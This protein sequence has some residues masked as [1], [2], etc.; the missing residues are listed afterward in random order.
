ME[1]GEIKSDSTEDDHRLPVPHYMRTRRVA[2]R[3]LAASIT[4]AW[5][6]C[7][8]YGSM[9]LARIESKAENSLEQPLALGETFWALRN[10]DGDPRCAGFLQATLD[11]KKLPD[12]K[13]IDQSQ[14]ELKGTMRVGL[15]DKVVKA[16]AVANNIFDEQFELSSMHTV[17]YFEQGSVTFS[18]PTPRE[19]LSMEMQAGDFK[20]K[21]RFGQVGTVYL[22]QENEELFRLRLPKSLR[23][24]IQKR[25]PDVPRPPI[26]ITELQDAVEVA[27]CRADVED[28]SSSSKHALVDVSEYLTLI[29]ATAGANNGLFSLGQENLNTGSSN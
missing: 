27:Q 11:Q 9:A 18:L 15:K 17:V 29:Q 7:L 28:V 2:P 8:A 24:L 19:A 14:L 5:F 25:G 26:E 4:L 1:F 21:I 3:V 10:P 12:G 16:T 22:V 20:H 23:G 6:V 13:T